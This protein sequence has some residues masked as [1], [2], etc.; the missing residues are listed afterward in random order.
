[1]SSSSIDLDKFVE[2]VTVTL[3]KQRDIN[4]IFLKEINRLR[5][6]VFDLEAVAVELGQQSIQQKSVI[7]HISRNVT[8]V[9]TK[10]DK[11]WDDILD[12]LLLK[13]PDI[14]KD[15]DDDDVVWVPSSREL[16]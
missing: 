15:D 8:S 9:G 4:A 13:R 10:D 16:I 12:S 5:D 1:M 11:T 6:K 14:E 3:S 2:A 7:Q